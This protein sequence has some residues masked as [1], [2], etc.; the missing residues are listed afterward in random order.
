MVICMSNKNTHGRGGRPSLSE[1][2][3]RNKVIKISLT[4]KEHSFV[5]KYANEAGY[6]Q[7]ARFLR[8]VMLGMIEQGHFKYVQHSIEHFEQYAMLRNGLNN[9]NQSTRVLNEAAKNGYITYD[10][11]KLHAKSTELLRRE[12]VEVHK[13]LNKGQESSIYIDDMGQ[14]YDS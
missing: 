7:V 8:A 14:H 11:A 10:L 12:L 5:Q 4:D 1:G 6:K 13:Q 9:L 2:E 3:K